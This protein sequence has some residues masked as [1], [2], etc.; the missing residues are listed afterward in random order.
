MPRLVAERADVL[1]ALGEV[2][3]E[4]GVAGAS[5]SII[6]EATGL[7]KGSLY[8]FF[9]G[10][11][12]EMVAAVLAQIDGWFED[13]VFSPL[14]NAADPRRAIDDM[15]DAVTDYFDSGSR[16]CLVG[17]LALVDTRDSFSDAIR[18]YFDRWVKALARALKK[19]GHPRGH[20]KDQAEHIVLGIQGAL[21]LARASHDNAV[22][23]RAISR[24]RK[25]F[26]MP[27]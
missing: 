25:S 23:T 19:L 27:Q 4:H 12:E 18:S 14:D 5:L 8:H 10:G 9:P 22:F 26:G 3:R 11:K 17:A 13:N 21:V 24:L 1:P 16:V 6:T 15:F 20:A 2:F 7:G